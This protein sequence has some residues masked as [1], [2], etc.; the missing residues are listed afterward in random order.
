MS[1]FFQGQESAAFLRCLRCGY[2]WR[3]RW[4]FDRHAWRVPKRCASCRSPLWNT[5][6]VNHWGQGRKRMKPIGAPRTLISQF[7]S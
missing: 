3:P 5:P 1:A 6:R 4:D 7:R 2:R